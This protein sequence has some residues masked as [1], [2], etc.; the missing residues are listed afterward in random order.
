MNEVYKR[1]CNGTH[2]ISCI[3]DGQMTVT[4]D[5]PRGCG[6]NECSTKEP[7]WPRKDHVPLQAWSD[8]GVVAFFVN[9]IV[10][11]ALDIIMQSNQDC[12]GPW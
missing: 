2:C 5:T 3:E 11:R 10:E 12:D 6:M 9:I 8:F 7:R 4:P 1:C